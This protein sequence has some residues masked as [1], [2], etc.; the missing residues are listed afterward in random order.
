M[1]SAKY[2]SKLFSCHYESATNLHSSVRL[3]FFVDCICP[4]CLGSEL[5]TFRCTGAELDTSGI[6]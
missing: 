3:D 2:F 4:L 6:F 5:A 1:T